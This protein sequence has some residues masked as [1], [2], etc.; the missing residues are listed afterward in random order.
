M[1]VV[2]FRPD[3]LTRVDA[4]VGEGLAG[5]WVELPELRYNGRAVVPEDWTLEQVHAALEDVGLRLTY[6]VLCGRLYSRTRIDELV[7][8]R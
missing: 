2:L 7:R 1:G 5:W 3:Q 6:N 4:D 8:K